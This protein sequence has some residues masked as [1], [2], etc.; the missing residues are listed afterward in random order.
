MS[1]V[2]LVLGCA[3]TTPVADSVEVT[4]ACAV[5]GDRP[6]SWTEEANGN[7]DPV[8]ASVF[9]RTVVHS[10]S[11]TVAAEDYEASDTELTDLIG[12]FGSGGGGGGGGGGVQPAQP[13]AEE[14]SAMAAACTG[15]AAGDSCSGTVD[16]QAF[17]GSCEQM[18][19]QLLCL[20][21]MGDGGGGGVDLIGADP[22]YF[23][24]TVQSDDHTWCS[25]GMR[26]KGNAT[27]SQSWNAGIGKLPFRLDFEQYEDEIPAV[28]N[29]RYYGF[30][31]MGFGN[32]Q[33]DGTLIRDVLAS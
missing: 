20:P 8:Y 4:E 3:E 5:N 23:P 21:A 6:S 33:G 30:R 16:G 9:D 12:E 19:P 31:E 27:L 11:L 13:S 18:G 7:V 1:L 24:V 10:I 22:S 25:V 29:Q 17:T 14:L 26:W 28:D 2:L 32:G 15:A